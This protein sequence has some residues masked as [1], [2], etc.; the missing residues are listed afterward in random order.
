M[1][2]LFYGIALAA[3]SGVAMGAALKPA[4]QAFTDDITSAP[5][6]M[7]SAVIIDQANAGPDYASSGPWVIGT[8]YLRASEPVPVEVYMGDIE[9]YEVAVSDQP[10]E[11]VE[12]ASAPEM[13]E[14]RYPSQGGGIVD[15]PKSAEVIAVFPIIDPA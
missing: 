5:P 2:A 11:P 4:L 13:A 3:F 1:K 14:P 9:P 7:A 8:D 12:P 15:A 6:G 10:A